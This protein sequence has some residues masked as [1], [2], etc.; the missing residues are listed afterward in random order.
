[1][2]RYALFVLFIVVAV[3]LA[4]CGGS[5]PTPTAQVACATPPTRTNAAQDDVAAGA[6]VVYERIGVGACISEVWSFYP[7]G[8]I[9][10]NTGQQKVEKKVTAD[11]ISTMVS[12][13]EK[14]GFSKLA[15][16]THTACRDCFTYYITV[17]T[18][19]QTKT[20][21]AVDGGTDTPTDYWQVFAK[22][23]RLT[24]TN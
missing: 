4:A 24:T 14:L 23:K 9:T 8:R 17:K 1:M 6:V 15:S 5:A 13:I 12:D 10:G 7:D 3:W 18:S 11:E 16:T 19:S 22:I 21:S 20:V 2:K